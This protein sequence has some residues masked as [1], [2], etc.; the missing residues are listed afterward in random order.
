[1]RDFLA[2]CRREAQDAI[3]RRL[4]R[5]VAESDLP[6]RVD[7]AAFAAFYYTV[8][9]GLS[10]QARDGA[11]RATLAAI[12]DCAIAAWDRL[13]RGRRGNGEKNAVVAGQPGR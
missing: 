5:G 11:S 13:A 10:V 9:Q 1:M 6:K 7:V 4:A 12:V 8:L 2:R 3:E